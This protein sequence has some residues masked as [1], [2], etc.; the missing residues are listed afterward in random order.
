M[1]NILALS[2]LALAM[3]HMAVAPASAHGFVSQPQSR[4]AFCRNVPVSGCGDVRWE[5]QSVEALKGSFACNGDGAR[6]PELNDEAL[7][8][9]HF[10]QV[11]SG[12]LSFTWTLTAPHRT[13]T[14]EY[15]ILL[16][17]GN[18]LLTSFNDGGAVPV[19][20]VVHQVPLSGYTGRRTILARWNIGDTPMAFYACVDLHIS[21]TNTAMTVAGAAATQLP[22]DMPLGGSEL[23]L[24]RMNGSSSA[25]TGS[26]LNMPLQNVLVTQKGSS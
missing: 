20:P 10:T 15:F 4:Q 1:I 24:A 7:W 3:L 8:T 11:Q 17:E 6:F 26:G 2:S 12:P 22:I 16:N 18:V 21:P 13:T 14:W 19:S 23:E 25:D 9:N 5:P